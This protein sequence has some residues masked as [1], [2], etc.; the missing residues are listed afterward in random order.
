MDHTFQKMQ[1]GGH[2]ST[3][4]IKHQSSTYSQRHQELLQNKHAAHT[5]H[6]QTSGSKSKSTVAT[7]K[8]V[9]RA[10]IVRSMGEV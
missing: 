6:K 5:D 7:S 10:Y 2:H 9:G 1:S 3:M 4:D 8:R